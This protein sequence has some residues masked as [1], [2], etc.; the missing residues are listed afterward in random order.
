MC[1]G[2]KIITIRSTY[3]RHRV[4]PRTKKKRK[5]ITI[6]HNPTDPKDSNNTRWPEARH[7]VRTLS[8]EIDVIFSLPRKTYCS[9]FPQLQ[10]NRLVFHFR[11]THAFPN[12]QR[13]TAT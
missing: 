6:F 13:T 1:I 11:T 2:D 3:L 8:F 4:Y 7:Y 10:V 9:C 5:V 12:E